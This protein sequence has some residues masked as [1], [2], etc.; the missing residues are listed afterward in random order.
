MACATE[1]HQS[2][3]RCGADADVCQEHSCGNEAGLAVIQVVEARCDNEARCEDCATDLSTEKDDIK[4]TKDDSLSDS[5]PAPAG[6]V[7]SPL[8]SFREVA[9]APTL[10]GKLACRFASKNVLLLGLSMSVLLA[11]SFPILGIWLSNQYFII[12]DVPFPIC[13]SSLVA[14]MYVF[15]GLYLETADLKTALSSWQ[16]ILYGFAATFVITPFFGLIPLGFCHFDEG[17]ALGYI[18]FYCM[19]T[20]L[21]SG[22]ALVWQAGGN[23]PLAVLLTIGSNLL[24][25]LVCPLLLTFLLGVEGVDI[26][27]SC[28]L[29]RL[30]VGVIFPLLLG[31]LLR[32][33]SQRVRDV[34]KRARP[35][36]KLIQTFF[37]IIIAWMKLS[38]AAHLIFDIE[39]HEMLKILMTSSSIHVALLSFHWVAA[40]VFLLDSPEAACL[41]ILCAEKTFPVA[42][43][44]I[45]FLRP[46]QVGNVGLLLIPTVM[47]HFVQLFG[48]SLLFMLWN[49]RTTKSSKT[50]RESIDPA[51]MQ[52]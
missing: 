42:V 28:L 38:D 9:E 25:I 10:L 39:W 40:R 14:I 1:R 15:N 41:I 49:W 48:D 50:N 32:M 51:A 19:P 23:V 46:Q 30:S 21:G 29:I 44:V 31:K 4:A 33:S 47:S 3:P 5:K 34:A 37:V 20:T 12:D 11:F 18:V 8:K 16:A 26:C 22:V 6:S 24:G 2:S 36:V 17:I 7:K 35:A 27:T 43:T 13:G 45:S 52:V